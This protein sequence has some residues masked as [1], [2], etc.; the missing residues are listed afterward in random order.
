MTKKYLANFLIVALLNFPLFAQNKQDKQAVKEAA[1]VAR[2]KAA[3]NKLGIGKRA[4]VE[5]KLK[6]G[7]SRRGYI[8]EVRDDLFVVTDL[9]DDTDKSELHFAD[10]HSVKAYNPSAVNKKKVFWISV[11]VVGTVVGTI[12]LYK[13]CKRI[14][15]EGRMCFP[16][17]EQY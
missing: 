12:F 4:M 17:E 2:H 5:V 6:S 10:L 13:H 14:E 15:K 9:G 1:Q 8:S 16:D 11:A 3:V 7:I